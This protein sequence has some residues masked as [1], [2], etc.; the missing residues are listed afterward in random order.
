M[1]SRRNSKR[2]N[3]KRKLRRTKRG[4]HSTNFELNKRNC[5]NYWIG[6]QIP[7]DPLYPSD[8]NAK[9]T[10]SDPELIS[11]DFPGFDRTY[12]NSSKPTLF[13]EDQI[14]NMRRQKDSLLM[15]KMSK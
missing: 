12:R 10:C 4:G 1:K 14:E 15:S 2:Q 5:N 13:T 3:A 9:F 11:Y 8:P 6:K 7:Q